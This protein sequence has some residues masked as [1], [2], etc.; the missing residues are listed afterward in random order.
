MAKALNVSLSVTADT[1][2]AAAALQK[3]K[4]QITQLQ[5]TSNNISLGGTLKQDAVEM[6]KTLAT[7]QATLK[8]ATNLQTGN[9][10]LTK[11]TQA[12]NQ[13]NMSLQKYQAQLTSLGPAG[14][15]AFASLANSIVQAEVPLRNANGLL[16]QFAT[17]LA[18]TARWQ[19][20]SSLLHGFMGTIS[21]AFHYAQDLNESLN[22]IQ[23]VTQNSDNQMAAFAKSANEAAK[24]L[25]TTTTAYTDAALIYYQQGLST[26]EVKERTDVTIKMANAAGV[27]AKTVSDQMTAVW[28]NFADGTKSL[29]YYADVM[30]ALGAATASSTDE[31]SAGLQKFASVA[32]TVGLSYENAAAALATI[33]ATTRQSADSVGTGLR[34]LFARLQSLKLGE[35]L[36]DG[37]DLTK[38]TK[39]LQTVGVSALD[40]AG[41]LRSMDDVLAD[42]GDKWEELSNTQ[43]V[44]L[45]QTVGGVRQYTTLMALMEHNE[46]FKQ[47]QQVALGSE[48][49]VQ[50][51]Q[52]TYAQSWEAAQKRVRAS[53]ETI[54][55]DLINDDFFIQLNEGLAGF[56][57]LVH[58]VIDGMGGLKGVFLAIGSVATTVF[59]KQVATGLQNMVNDIKML[60]PGGQANV[61]NQKNTA[62]ELL[63][64]SAD[65]SG[66]IVGQSMA[67]AYTQQAA[68][69][70][71]YVNNAERMSNFQRDIA[72]SMLQQQQALVENVKLS[73]EQAENAKQQ[74]INSRIDANKYINQEIAGYVQASQKQE[75][76]KQIN[77][78]RANFSTLLKDTEIEGKVQSFIKTFD[79]IDSIQNFNQALSD[80][81]LQAKD[82][83]DYFGDQLGPQLTK[84][85]EDAIKSGNPQELIK[86]LTEIQNKFYEQGGPGNSQN[87]FDKL[88]NSIEKLRT[89]VPNADKEIDALLQKAEQMRDTGVLKGEK[90][91]ELFKNQGALDAQTKALQKAMN[92]IANGSYTA[93]DGIVALAGT[94]TSLGYTVQ[95]VTHLFDVWS[96]SSTSGSQKI[97]ALLTT[98][99]PLLTTIKG[100]TSI[101][102]LQA[103]ASIGNGITSTLFNVSINT[104]AVGEAAAAASSGVGAFG[105]AWG[106]A[107]LQMGIALGVIVALGAAIWLIYRAATSNQAA[108][109]RLSTSVENVG[110]DLE[111]LKTMSQNLRQEFDE[112]DSIYQQLEKCAEGSSD[113]QQNMSQLVAMTNEL[114]EKYPILNQYRDF[115]KT[116]T[117]GEWYFD[118]KTMQETLFPALE[119]TEKSLN[120]LEALAKSNK[121]MKEINDKTAEYNA[122]QAAVTQEG[123]NVYELNKENAKTSF[124]QGLFTSG[125]YGNLDTIFTNEVIEKIFNAQTVEEAQKIFQDAIT[126]VQ[127]LPSVYEKTR[128]KTTTQSTANFEAG[129]INSIVSSIFGGTGYG[130]ANANIIDIDDILDRAVELQKEREIT[131]E[132][133]KELYGEDINDQEWQTVLS[134]FNEK[135]QFNAPTQPSKEDLI[136][137][138]KLSSR[139]EFQAYI[140]PKS[141]DD[142]VNEA[143]AEL[144]SQGFYTEQSLQKKLEEYQLPTELIQDIINQ[145]QEGLTALDLSSILS[146]YLTNS[147]ETITEEFTEEFEDEDVILAKQ[148]IEEFQEQLDGYITTYFANIAEQLQIKTEHDEEIEKLQDELYT[149]LHAP[150]VSYLKTIPEYQELP[151][152]YLDQVTSRLAR[153]FYDSV[154]EQI[155]KQSVEEK[156]AI[157][158][159]TE[160]T[161]YSSAGNLE[162]KKENRELKYI[163]TDPRGQTHEVTE[164]TLKQYKAIQEASSGE[165][166]GGDTTAYLSSLVND[167]LGTAQKDIPEIIESV[168]LKGV[169]GTE[170]ATY[171]SSIQDI[172][173]II[174]EFY[175]SNDLDNIPIEKI[176]NYYSQLKRIAE[177][178]VLDD[179]G[180]DSKVFGSY[181]DNILNLAEDT[182]VDARAH[183]VGGASALASLN[184]T[185]ESGPISNYAE[186]YVNTLSNFITNQLGISLKENPV[187]F[188]K[189]LQDLLETDISQLNTKASSLLEKYGKEINDSFFSEDF[190][191]RSQRAFGILPVFSNLTTQL[192]EVSDIV[193]D[194]DLGSVIKKEDYDKLIAYN[195]EW[196]GFFDLQADGKY[197]VNNTKEAIQNE[198]VSSL[199][200]GQKQLQEYALA[201]QTV[202]EEFKSKGKEG[203]V[204]SISTDEGI[205]DL[206]AFYESDTAKGLLELLEYHSEWQK[207][208]KDWQ[209]QLANTLNALLGAGF[210]EQ[211]ASLG[212][213][214]LS[215]ASDFESLNR[216]YN[217]IQQVETNGEITGFA[218]VEDYVKNFERIGQASVY[219][220]QSLT[221]LNKALEQV[222]IEQE[223]SGGKIEDISSIE[224]RAAQ[225]RLQIAKSYTDVYNTKEYETYYDLV[226]KSLDG[227]TDEEKETHKTLLK[228][229]EENLDA[230]MT[231]YE[232]V[233]GISDASDFFNSDSGLKFLESFLSLNGQY[234]DDS[235]LAMAKEIFP[236][237]ANIMPNDALLSWVQNLISSITNTQLDKALQ[238]LQNLAVALNSLEFGKTVDDN[239]YKN[240]IKNNS[241]LKDYFLTQIDGS[242]K[243]IGNQKQLRQATKATVEQQKEQIKTNE[244]LF[245]KDSLIA[246]YLK[247]ADKSVKDKAKYIKNRRPEI[248][249]NILNALGMSE[250]ELN[251]IINGTASE[252]AQ[253]LFEAGL[254][255]L[256]STDYQE[257]LQQNREIMASLATTYK[258]LDEMLADEKIEKSDYNKRWL[259]ITK[260]NLMAAESLDEL[261]LAQ[262]NAERKKPKDADESFNAAIVEDYAEGLYKIASG[263]DIAASAANA[264]YQAT[265]DE[266]DNFTKDNNQLKQQLQLLTMI[267][268]LSEGKASSSLYS[269]LGL[270]LQNVL[271]QL[272]ENLDYSDINTVQQLFNSNGLEFVTVTTEMI[273]AL[274][275]L[276]EQVPKT[277]AVLDELA[278]KLADIQSLIANLNFGDMISEE[279]YQ[280][281]KKLV[282]LLEGGEEFLRNFVLTP[283][284][285]WE[286]IGSDEQAQGM[287]KKASQEN[288]VQTQEQLDILKEQQKGLKS[289]FGEKPIT[290]TEAADYLRN[291]P[292][293]AENLLQA[294]GYSQGAKEARRVLR[295]SDEADQA[296]QTKLLTALTNARDM[297]LE[298]AQH[299]LNMNEL[300][301]YD[302]LEKLRA[303]EKNGELTS[304]TSEERDAQWQKIAGDIITTTDKFEKLEEAYQE[305]QEHAEN[306]EDKAAGID[307]RNEA[308]VR[309]AGSYKNTAEELE[310]YNEIKQQYDE[311]DESRQQILQNQLELTKIA[312]EEAIQIGQV[313]KEHEI[314]DLDGL[315]AYTRYLQD[316]VDHTISFKDALQLAAEEM[317]RDS[318]V[319]NLSS[320]LDSILKTLRDTDEAVKNTKKFEKAEDDLKESLEDI[321]DLDLDKVSDELLEWAK[322]GD[323]LKK[324]I[325]GDK[326]AWE[327]MLK[328]NT[329][330]LLKDVK[331]MKSQVEKLTDLAGEFA[332]YNIGDAIDSDQVKEVLDL[333]DQ[334]GDS[335]GW[336][337]A[338]RNE[339][340]NQIMNSVGEYW[341]DVQQEAPVITLDIEADTTGAATTMEELVAQ[342]ESQQITSEYFIEQANK[343]VEGDPIKVKGHVDVQGLAQVAGGQLIQGETAEI[344]GGYDSNGDMP[345]FKTERIDGGQN[346][347]TSKGRPSGGGGGGGGGGGKQKKKDYKKPD[348]SKRYHTIRE[349]KADNDR[350]KQAANREKE[351][352]FGAERIKQSENEIKLQKES[353]DLQRQYI[354]E[355]NGYLQGD[356]NEMINAVSKLKI[357]ID[358]QFDENGV[359]ENYREIEAALLAQENA[360]ID[361]YNNGSIDDE[362]YEEAQK[363]ID[364]A[365]EYIGIYEETLNL[366]EEQMDEMAQMLNELS[367]MA[368][369]LTKLKV[370]LKIEVNDDTLKL[371]E[372]RLA[373]I[374]D[375]AYKTAEAISLIGDKTGATIDKIKNWEQGLND[376]FEGHG[377]DI[378]DINNWTDQQLIEAGFTQN[379]IEWVRELRDNMIDAAQEIVK[380]RQEMLDM[381]TN[382]Y[383]TLYERVTTQY[384]LFDH[385]NTVLDNYKNITDLMGRTMNKDQRNLIQ[386]LN[387]NILANQRNQMAAA[388]AT[389][390]ELLKQQE[391]AQKHYNDVVA[392][393]DKEAILQWEAVLNNVNEKVT[394]AHENWLS[395]WNDAVQTARDNFEY[396]LEGII[397][398]FNEAMAG[399]F[400]NLDYLSDA[401]E[402][403][404][405]TDEQYLQDYDRLYELSKLQRDLNNTLSD[406]RGLENRKALLALQ[407]EI[408]ELQASGVRLSQYD[409][410]ALRKRYELEQAYADLLDSQD[411]KHTVRLQRNNE[412]MWG[413]VYTVDED[414]VAEAEQNYEDKLHEYQQLNDEYI[415]E[416]Q[417]RVLETQQTYR[418]TLEEIMTDTTLTD[419]QR[420]ARINELNDWLQAE[421]YFFEQQLNN[422]MNNQHD[423]L[424]RYYNAYEDTRAQLIDSWTETN[425]SLLTN[426]SSMQDYMTNWSNATE[427]LLS[428]ALQ[429]LHDSNE[430][431]AGINEESGVES[432]DYAGTIAEVSEQIAT[433]SEEIEAA[434][435]QLAEE[436]NEEFLKALDMAIAKEEEWNSAISST[437]DRVD[438]LAE[439]LN[440]LIDRLTTLESFDVGLV[441]ARA[442]YQAAQNSWRQGTIDEAE[443]HKA[444]QEWHD[445][446][447]NWMAKFDEGGYTGAWGSGGKMAIL[448][449]RENVFNKDDTQKLL[450]AAKIL[451]IIDLQSS[452]MIGGIGALNAPTTTG[453]VQT[454]EQQVTISAEFPNVT[455]HY[456]IE[457][458]FNNLVNKATQYANEKRNG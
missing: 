171:K 278:S 226:H 244:K 110:N 363:K 230:L 334:I 211:Y 55:S 346:N 76:Q 333:I 277:T 100:I 164:T 237:L 27:S 195:K 68:L 2:Q 59:S 90:D 191:T 69:Q 193:Q 62:I 116:N 299:R 43:K 219:S 386:N 72:N 20:S 254:L 166:F 331:N 111:E 382:N 321:L 439:S 227:L 175:L 70:E 194:L 222:R 136:L 323:N 234:D 453:F 344:T 208:N 1:Q 220:A 21:S 225:R 38:Y 303:A 47:N 292:A 258:E 183:T 357:G 167:I 184:K 281:I 41:E 371:L 87:T 24:A 302:S 252:S 433:S 117:N 92:D 335:E 202:K 114:L 118:S 263:Y 316:A 71:T 163:Y 67:N 428:S 380:A 373:R 432:E 221:E 179:I 310:K 305:Y 338:T 360:L 289:S 447:D 392:T 243:F 445:Y 300:S 109:A 270:N 50:K 223:K 361:K 197:R 107:G 218:N 314:T 394:E 215:L 213:Q 413:Y 370:E 188:D 269:G 128:T 200:D 81:K 203:H 272:P 64:N 268:E 199:T 31:I 23:I 329:K 451:R 457:E 327:E 201:I 14:Q 152:D 358:F 56:L 103:L 435:A 160:Y 165:E 309:L 157:D 99:G 296:E 46:F 82:I 149:T 15:Q 404:Q 19:I 379:E 40:A 284:G 133:L 400:G 251:A 51:Q 102:T 155:D 42:L 266:A 174:S 148:H 58:Q 298:D 236:Q 420:E 448:H 29:E 159:F 441:N 17:T 389:Y 279:D 414:A 271:R 377:L 368:L 434:V 140:H 376:L 330:G 235:L 189:I 387:R 168:L 410:D 393:G 406:T 10:D 161:G 138:S 388:K 324:V 458:A 352:A 350:N 319:K 231:Q 264:Y 283:S 446:L 242:Y 365:R 113:W 4:Q 293:E 336:D 143:S 75:Y 120:L 409:V 98:L 287:A 6:N 228:N 146:E 34:T 94:L 328:V 343:I 83:G 348:V 93:M 26:K 150:L 422:A 429:A 425:L 13:S 126:T 384:D 322:Q 170:R 364:E 60:L 456:E 326:K 259:E 22:R 78:V 342:Y 52:E 308:L 185:L 313:G 390:E 186:T 412:G 196:K 7:L 18:N 115:L 280:R 11:F 96:D 124:I 297:D 419:E 431:I 182:A 353:V 217:I 354:E 366:Y 398:S 424:T 257:K 206:K 301:Q 359:I 61:L 204:F 381:L 74:T 233:K 291:H 450:D 127:E 312:L 85:L 247:D 378:N 295:S 134:W 311:A 408:N 28:N 12:M 229:A 253:D 132:Q 177:S 207:D 407:R 411:A 345:T 178:G 325:N 256:T 238:N 5:T 123:K 45:A 307:L 35:T 362:A 286:Y 255:Q 145:A 122:R 129:Q 137:Q 121:I 443:W 173:K 282:E 57:D 91:F 399:A 190:L 49:T 224:E 454:L 153:Q 250:A 391:A 205:E 275:Q 79:K 240:I 405:E 285:Q 396:M 356:K 154:G 77:E 130:Y 176:E 97:I 367:D 156:D 86:I 39:A 369:E 337:A 401:F 241:A 239:T 440:T 306:D 210:Q 320:N 66:S 37:V 73:A 444:E 426:I 246:S 101:N 452:S 131:F 112:Y 248:T 437:A 395:S 423:T 318:A 262:Q 385:Y 30:T 416:L 108:L 438:S 158:Y 151:E 135:G 198:L 162:R 187:E 144:A 232:S 397:E 180:I 427:E 417:S 65:K 265:H 84:G 25:S 418:D 33:T 105:A 212:D 142:Y 214:T 294:I 8:N 421:M 332:D 403:K 260:T 139:R 415:K 172:N 290:G 36:E 339:K 181:I 442:K 53:A 192:N 349:H 374:E 54:F 16:S 430:E 80:L 276:Q 44:A 216:L 147:I 340:A 351:R 119:E 63:K 245:G 315:E 347:A 32:N 273:D 261:N 104:A 89:I 274:K 304:Y 106:V 372:Y 375:N 48:G 449:E 141:F 436:L 209:A 355:I 249:E 288:F 341:Q 402:R 317:E 383:D 9:L 169:T 267:G 125:Q 3:L 455:D 95:R 88:V